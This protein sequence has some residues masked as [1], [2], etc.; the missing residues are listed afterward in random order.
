VPYLAVVHLRELD[1]AECGAKIAE[2][3]ARS[4]VVGAG[5][6]PIHFDEE[7]VPHEMTLTIACPQGHRCTLLVPNEVA[8][9]ETMATPEAAP[10]A[11]DAVLSEI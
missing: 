2:P 10:I 1:C 9:E 4:F 3:G 8:A 5:G 11:A 7:K 6:S